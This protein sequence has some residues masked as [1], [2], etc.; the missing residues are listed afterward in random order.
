M[1]VESIHLGVER[2]GVQEPTGWGIEFAKNIDETDMTTENELRLLCEKLDPT[3]STSSRRS[4]G[5]SHRS[6]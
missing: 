2:E 1:V 6:G 4:V 5:T 3:G